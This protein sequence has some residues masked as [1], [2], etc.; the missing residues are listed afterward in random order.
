M[1]AGPQSVKCEGA[2]DPDLIGV[3]S[4]LKRSGSWSGRE[5]TIYSHSSITDFLTLAA[6]P[7]DVLSQ[8]LES[9]NSIN[10]GSAPSH[11]MPS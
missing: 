4:N 1:Q 8:S 2:C 11:P 9:C 3:I 6:T 7:L 5:P 10:N